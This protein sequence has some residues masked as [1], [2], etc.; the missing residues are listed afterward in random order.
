MKVVA[1]LALAAAIAVAGVAANLYLLGVGGV[2][3]DPVGRL[4][5]RSVSTLPTAPGTTT[6]QPTTTD[7][8]RGHTTGHDGDGD[9]D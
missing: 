6:D 4:T 2:N 8:D 1:G 3:A 7:D 5:P 9:D